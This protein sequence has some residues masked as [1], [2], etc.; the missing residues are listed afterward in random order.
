MIRVYD[1][2]GIEFEITPENLIGIL[3]ETTVS[4]RGMEGE[5]V[6]AWK[7]TEIIL[8]PVGSEEYQNASKFTALQDQKVSA[9]DLKEGHSYTTKK[10]EELI[11]M[12]RFE[13]FSWKHY[14]GEDKGRVGKK[15]H[16]FCT[17]DGKAHPGYADVQYDEDD[18][19][20]YRAEMARAQ[21]K[22]IGAFCPYEPSKLA[23]CNTTEPVSNFAELIENLKKDI[24]TSKV[25]KVECKP[26]KVDLRSKRKD[27]SYEYDYHRDR[28]PTPKKPIYYKDNGDSIVSYLINPHYEIMRDDTET[29]KYRPELKGFTL[30]SQRVYKKDTLSSNYTPER[31]TWTRQPAVYSTET[32]EKKLADMVDVYIEIEGG[33]RI[34]FNNIEELQDKW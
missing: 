33:H 27:G 25:I 30:A 29:N 1:P 13:W 8:L 10:G 26:A 20:A 16:I 17:P 3:T 9:H 7:G 23:S 22:L 21:K 18:D 5:F 31:T 11:Y 24:H 19:N 34:N 2:R 28:A 12:G 4:K 6:Y 32:I 14:Y 15:Q